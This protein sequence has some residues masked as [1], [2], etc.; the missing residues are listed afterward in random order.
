M[1][2]ME[3]PRPRRDDRR[4]IRYLH[5]ELPAAEA[6][7]L[8]AELQRDPALT[9]RLVELRRLWSGLQPPPPTPAP[10]F[11]PRLQRLAEERRRTA[12]ASLLGW[13]MAPPWARALAG[14]ALLAGVALGIGLGRL[15]AR[16]AATASGPGAATVAG[17]PMAPAGQVPVPANERGAAV[18]TSPSTPPA[19][20]TTPGS[21]P[22][23]VIQQQSREQRAP[24]SAAAGSATTDESASFGGDTLAEEYWQALAGTAGEGGSGGHSGW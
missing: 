11:V 1:T 3:R 23:V 5:G 2:T 22:G 15:P 12:G 21:A 18:S 17:A 7:L 6:R 20:P 14:A 13:G 8:E 24:A 4:L 16:P 9:A 10:F 19:V